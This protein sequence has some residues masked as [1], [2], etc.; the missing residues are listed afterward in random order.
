LWASASRHY[1]GAVQADDATKV[2]HYGIDRRYLK[3]LGPVGHSPA[4]RSF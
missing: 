4:I 2:S 1:P 3:F